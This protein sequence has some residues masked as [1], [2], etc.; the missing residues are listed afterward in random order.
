MN[1]RIQS[2]NDLLEEKQRLQS[3]LK[4]QKEEL[5]EDF[6]E[7]KEDLKPV[8][9]ALSFAG[10]LVTRD[11]NNWVLNAGV[12]SLIDL[13]LKKVVLSRTGWFTKFIVPFLMKNYSSHV[14]ADKKGSLMNKLF[15]WIGKKNANGKH[16]T[17][18]MH[19]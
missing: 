10:K 13:V 18:E 11:N 2:Y 12:N 5:R 8:R 1:K 4:W 15:S 16:E 3:L 17:N 14:I 9:S 19:N 7:I 6:R